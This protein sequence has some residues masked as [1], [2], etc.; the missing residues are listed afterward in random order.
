M[1]FNK[2]LITA[3]FSLLLFSCGGIHVPFSYA[4]HDSVTEA[5]GSF[6]QLTSGEI[7]KTKKLQYKKKE[8]ILDSRTVDADGVQVWQDGERYA[9][10]VPGRSY[11]ID[12]IVKGKINVYSSSSTGANDIGR[13]GSENT[14][15]TSYYVQKGKSGALLP[16]T[17]N[18]LK[19]MTK[20]NDEAYA[21]AKKLKN[22]VVNIPKMEKVVKTYNE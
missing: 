12:R 10:K 7:I 2:F 20:D 3:I 13:G 1:T 18:V 4:K 17:P 19:E 16:M 14:T 8:F 9:A 21:L 15:N 5:G 6:I 11:F 22:I